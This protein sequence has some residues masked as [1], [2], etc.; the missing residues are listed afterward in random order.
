MN[1][2]DRITL[3]SIYT[4]FPHLKNI[5]GTPD[6][7]RRNQSRLDESTADLIE[8]SSVDLLGEEEMPSP[9]KRNETVDYSK[10]DAS[11]LNPI[12]S[13]ESK[14]FWNSESP[15]QDG[16]GLLESEGNISVADRKGSFRL[17]S[18]SARRSSGVGSGG[19]AGSSM[20]SDLLLEHEDPTSDTSMDGSG[21]IQ[22]RSSSV[23]TPQRFTPF[24]SSP[25]TKSTSPV[26][27][28][29]TSDSSIDSIKRRLERNEETM[30][31]YEQDL[32][33]MEMENNLLQEENAGLKKEIADLLKSLKSREDILMEVVD[34]M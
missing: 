26:G 18:P 6:R 3:Q 33:T 16:S 5:K 8:Y 25:L 31:Q 23:T 11:S 7:R 14:S 12:A 27:P 28:Q 22:I 10:M 15:S 32:G 34:M 1:S 29:D 9:L 30:H 19:L 21:S 13:L 4:K 24:A 20:T 2:S 17:S